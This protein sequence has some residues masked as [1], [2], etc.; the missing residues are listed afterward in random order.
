MKKL[1]LASLLGLTLS[2][3]FNSYAGVNVFGVDT[4]VERKN[5]RDNVNAGYVAKSLGDT[6]HVQKPG[7]TKSSENSEDREKYLVFGVDIN[8]L[9]NRI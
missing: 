2:F 8:T 1:L 3:P 5:V 4:P 9:N 7:A 6:F